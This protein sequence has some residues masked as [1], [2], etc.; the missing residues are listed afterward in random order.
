MSRFYE[1]ILLVTCICV[2]MSVAG[3]L[4]LETMKAEHE[5]EAQ[6]ELIDALNDLTSAQLDISHELWHLTTA[7][8]ESSHD[9]DWISDALGDAL[10]DLG[11]RLGRLELR[12]HG[13]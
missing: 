5:A 13:G 3:Q 7:M 6:A 1:C 10:E 12:V 9:I 11:G 4:R 8:Q 2:A